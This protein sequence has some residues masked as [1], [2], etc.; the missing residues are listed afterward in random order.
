VRDYAARFRGPLHVLVHNAGVMPDR[1]VLTSDGNELALATHVVGPHL[2]TALLRPALVEAQGGRV[3][4]VA[5]GGMYAQR[6]RVDD[7]QYED[8]AYRGATA[9]ARTKRMQVVLSE[10]WAARLLDDGVVVHAVHPGW[11]RTPGVASS[12]PV[13]RALTGPLLRTPEQ[14]ADTTVWVAAAEAPGRCTGRFWHDRVARPTHYLRRTRETPAE[15]EALW[16]ACQA[17]AGLDQDDAPA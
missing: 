3:V 15:R 7:L 8:G 17:L 11:A 10:C 2:L 14:G 9:Y 5:S 1:R 12:R 13:F 16:D 6:L 4:W